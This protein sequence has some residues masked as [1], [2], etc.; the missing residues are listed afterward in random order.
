M[1]SKYPPIEGGVSSQTYW[2]AKALG[3]RGHEVHIVTNAQEVEEE[4]REDIENEIDQYQPPNV[5]VHSTDPSPSANPSHIPFSKAYCEKLANLAIE[6]IEKHDIQI[7]DSWY[8]LPYA[9]SG[10]L[11]KT[12]T[13]KPQ[14]IRHA[15][16]DINRLF[17]SPYL[18]TLFKSILGRSDAIV[19]YSDSKEIFLN[20]GIPESK[21]FL[22]QRVAV[23]TTAFNPE[24]EPI[25]LS[26][27]TDKDTKN[28]PIITYIGKITYHSETKGIYELLE[29]C[30]GI[31]DDFLLLFVGDGKELK[32]F[33]EAV[34]EKRL[35]N[36][37]LFLNFVPPW[38]V[39]SII[40]RST[41]VVLPEQDFPISNHTP[42]IPKEVM[43]TG[44]CLLLSRELYQKGVYKGLVDGENILIIDPQNIKQFRS[45]LEKIIKNPRI[46]ERIGQEA[47]RLSELTEDFNKYVSHNILIYERPYSNET[48]AKR[49]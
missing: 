48:Q 1:I 6:V 17:A 49:L 37:T 33:Q 28:L 41:C 13:H 27:Y 42:S 38:K 19:T 23:D 11:A 10:F 46:A 5:Y 40:K 39:P 9:V 35:E 16:S 26:T 44:K 22:N 34:G 25:D 32:K 29:A 21:L 8:L 47:R 20:L 2:L 43:A 4:Y 7:I 12:I 14:I 31:K 15:G 3:E 24:V 30:Q 36:Q 45:T 18:K